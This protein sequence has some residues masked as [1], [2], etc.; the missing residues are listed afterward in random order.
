MIGGSRR[1][2]AA[3]EFAL[4]SVVLT[5]LASVAVD[6]G[7]F[8]T[9]RSTVAVAVAEGAKASA[10]MIEAPE[11]PYGA[12]LLPLAEDEVVRYLEASGVICG[13]G[14]QVQAQLQDLGGLW[15]LHVEAQVP[16]MDLVG[17]FPTRTL[18]RAEHTIL[19]RDQG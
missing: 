6:F 12:E 8:F 4:V 7:W 16:H 19:V 10:V 18:L 11:T 17:L 5:A 9:Q 14:C 15:A 1:G 13:S 2:S 3:A